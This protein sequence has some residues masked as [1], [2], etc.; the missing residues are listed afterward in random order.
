MSKMNEQET[1]KTVLNN[2]NLL[3]ESNLN[4]SSIVSRL[5]NKQEKLETYLKESFQALSDKEN[6]TIQQEFQYQYLKKLLTH[7]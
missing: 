4:L 3:T 5:L 7:K 1:L 6:R 2:N